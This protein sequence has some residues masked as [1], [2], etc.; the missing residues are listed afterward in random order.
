MDW[1]TT[2]PPTVIAAL[3][4]TQW[5]VLWLVVT[6]VAAFSVHRGRAAMTAAVVIV[7]V[8]PLPY[9]LGIMTLPITHENYGHVLFAA[10]L[11]APTLLLP[12][13]IWPQPD[14]AANASPGEVRRGLWLALRLAVLFAAAF[15][16]D[17]A[18]EA[19][20]TDAT[21]LQITLY[22]LYLPLLVVLQARWTA[23]STWMITAPALARR[24][25]L[26]RTLA[27]AAVT[28]LIIALHNDR[29]LPYA[30]ATAGDFAGD[31]Y[32]MHNDTRNCATLSAHPDHGVLQLKGEFCLTTP[33]TFDALRAQHPTIQRIVLDSPGGRAFGALEIGQRLHALGF[34]ARVDR[35]CSSACVTALVGAHRRWVGPDSWIGVHQTSANVWAQG[36]RQARW[37]ISNAAEIV[38]FEHERGV[39]ADLQARASETPPESID[40]LSPED[41]VAFGIAQLA[42]DDPWLPAEKAETSNELQA[43]P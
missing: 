20:D 10:A 43:T 9:E 24:P 13:L 15:V 1:L 5:P 42:T 28:T 26:R 19:L 7:I 39:S 34:D 29:T 32:A 16:I 37:A 31:E 25:R 11:L 14:A 2:T 12:G 41:V 33:A 8:L 17:A 23:A 4:F 36:N 22:F 38:A 6:V 40:F 21:D 27:A 18:F 3:A 30:L 35:Q